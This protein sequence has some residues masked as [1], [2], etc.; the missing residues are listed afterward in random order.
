[1][2]I[3]PGAVTLARVRRDDGQA[4][5]LDLCDWRALE[6]ATGAGEAVAALADEHE[7]GQMPVVTVLEPGSF[8]LLLVEAPE[9]DATELKAAVRWRIKDMLDFHIDDAVI[10]VFDIPGQRER[11]RTRMMY[12]VAARVSTVQ[13]RIDVL[14]GGGLALQVIDI[15]ELAQRNVAALLPEDADGVALLHLD[16]SGGLITLTHE[17]TLYLARSIDTGLEDLVSAQSEPVAS[18]AEDLS[19]DGPAPARQRAMDSIVLEVQR[20]LDYYESH[21]SQPPIKSL[22]IAPLARE[23]EG[24]VSYLAA[25]LGVQVR[26]LDLNDVLVSPEPLDFALQARCL[27]AIGAA[28]RREETVL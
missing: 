6:S 26:M 18:S 7:I 24:L 11:G 15:P 17:D 13:E 4:P 2:G 25:N 23:V 28:L 8:N 5:R 9:V 10:D 12:V 22:V 3:A 21:F 27:A 16:E 1:V 20:S 14:E 19:F